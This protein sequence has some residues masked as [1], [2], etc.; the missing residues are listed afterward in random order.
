[1]AESLDRHGVRATSESMPTNGTN[2][3]EALLTKARDLEAGMIVTGTYG[4]SRLREYV[5]GGAT[6]HALSAIDVP[7]LM[8][9]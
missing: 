6:R 4:H 8:L 9:H 5:L 2:P 1:M 7:L 3:S